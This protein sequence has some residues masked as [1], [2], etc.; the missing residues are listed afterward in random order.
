[1]AHREGRYAPFIGT[2][3]RTMVIEQTGDIDPEVPFGWSLLRPDAEARLAGDLLTLTGPDEVARTV[4]M[5]W[6]L[7]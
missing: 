1:M 2:F 4:G 7:P 3:Q 6:D 5:R